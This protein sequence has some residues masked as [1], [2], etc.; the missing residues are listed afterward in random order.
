MTVAHAKG[1]IGAFKLIYGNMPL[2]SR[3]AKH[4]TVKEMLEDIEQHLNLK[5]GD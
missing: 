2:N 4:I 5:E 3:I 1:C